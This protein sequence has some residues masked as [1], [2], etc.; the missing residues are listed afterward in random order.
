MTNLRGPSVQQ[1]G[2]KGRHGRHCYRA[3]RK[4]SAPSPAAA[5][6]AARPTRAARSGGPRA[7][8]PLIEGGDRAVR[9]FRVIE[10]VGGLPDG[11]GHG[12]HAHA[13]RFLVGAERRGPQAFIRGGGGGEEAT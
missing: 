9:R 8:W 11:G 5:V 7:P 10:V 12:S 13:T 2:T 1:A 6:T 4:P 3:L